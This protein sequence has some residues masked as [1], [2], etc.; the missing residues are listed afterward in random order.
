MQK[1]KEVIKMTLKETFME[2]MKNAMREKDTMKKNVV[3]MVRA[4]I[5]QYEVDNRV[6]LDDAGITEIIAKEVKKRKD[7]LPE[8][9]KSGRTELI[10]ELNSEINYLAKYLPEQMSEDEIREVVKSVIAETGAAGMKDMGKVM[11]A[12]KPQV[13]GKADNG[14]VSSIVKQCLSK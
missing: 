10:N 4:A 8:Y 1:L 5:K 14:K 12:V 11:G 2:E 6:E 13:N 7:S 9:E 3:T